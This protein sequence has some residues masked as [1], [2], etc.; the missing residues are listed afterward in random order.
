MI[1]VPRHY[2]EL[3][4]HIQQYL[5]HHRDWVSIIADD[6]YAHRFLKTVFANT[7]V[8]WAYER[9]NPVSSPRSSPRRHLAICCAVYLWWRVHRWRHNSHLDNYIKPDDKFI[10]S[11]GIKP[12]EPC[13]QPSYHLSNAPGM[14]GNMTIVQWMI[15]SASQHPFIEQALVNMVDV[16]KSIYTGQSVLLPK[17][18]PF[19]KLL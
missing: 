8:L 11:T 5:G 16:I 14:F 3:P 1:T 18:E 4:A 12:A 7:S 10:I 17:L 2:H 9:I 19:H 15:F 6:K 13:Y